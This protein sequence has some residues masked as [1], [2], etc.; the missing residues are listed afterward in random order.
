MAYELVFKTS[1]RHFLQKK[2]TVFAVQSNELLIEIE[3]EDSPGACI[4]LDKQTAIKFAKEL[5]RQISFL[6]DE[7][8]NN[9]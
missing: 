3:P 8:V 5:R 1:N 9:G 2:L 7:E 6:K 4:H